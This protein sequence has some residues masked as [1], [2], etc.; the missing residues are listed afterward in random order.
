MTGSLTTTALAVGAIS[1]PGTGSA[2]FAGNLTVFGFVSASGNL[3]SNSGQVIS[4][5]S[6]VQAGAQ[7][8][9]GYIRMQAP[10]SGNSGYVEFYGSNQ[11]RAG[12]IG[13]TGSTGSTDGGGIN[14]VA[15]FHAFN[16]NITATGNV[17]AYSSD[18]RLKK[19]VTIIENA[20]QKVLR[21]GG[22]S[23]DWD[24]PKCL[25]VGFQPANEHEHGLIAQ[26]VQRVMPDAVAPAPFN[27]KYLTVR[28][29]RIVALLTAAMGEQQRELD[30]LRA[31]LNALE[32]K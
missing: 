21:L 3:V 25:E 14:Y 6:S 19:N 29:E 18:G 28:Y 32:A 4:T 22:Y 2:N 27:D 9:T 15:A 1:M 26:D 24:M 31:R 8:T 10:G 20:V 17:T 5:N 7:G 13:N 16:G 12:Y 30:E 23:Y 11:V